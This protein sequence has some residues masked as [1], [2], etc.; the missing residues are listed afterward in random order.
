M[1]NR[2]TGPAYSLLT[3]VI[4]SALLTGCIYRDYERVRPGEID[5]TEPPPQL[6]EPERV[7]PDDSYHRGVLAYSVRPLWQFGRLPHEGSRIPN[8]HW[9]AQL[10][11][12]VTPRFPIPLLGI[13][14]GCAPCTSNH[15]GGQRWFVEADVNVFALRLGAGWSYQPV[16]GQGGPQ[17]TLGISEIFQIRW[18]NHGD[19]DMAVLY[20]LSIP[21]VYVFQVL[22]Y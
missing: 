4:A 18:V 2:T 11:I 17:I 1:I 10:N 7:I 20:D 22:T 5:V 14:G 9:G 6:E 15:P 16:T 8:R 13:S 21:I 3:I 19:T 12:G